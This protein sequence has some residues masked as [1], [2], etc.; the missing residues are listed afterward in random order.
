MGALTVVIV[1][2]V[3]AVAASGSPGAVEGSQGTDITLPTTNSSYTVKVSD[4]L[5]TASP[6]A[7]MTITVS[8][9][10]N[11]SNQ[12]V[13]VHWTGATPTNADLN[14]TGLFDDNYLQMFECWGPPDPSTPQNPGPGPD[15]CEFG[16]NELNGAM[17]SR[18]D[19][20]SSPIIRQVAANDPSTYAFRDPAGSGTYIP[21]QPVDG[22]SPINIPTT[23]ST[24][25]QE[26]GTIWQNP[27]FDYTTSNEIDYAR[28]YPDGTGTTLFTVDTGL[29]APGVGCGQQISQPDGSSVQPQCW[30]V[31]VPRGSAT[32]ENPAGTASST[33]PAVQTSPLSGQAFAHR[34]AIPLSFNAVGNSCQL[35]SNEERLVGSEL[36][37]PAVINWEPALCSTPKSPPY[38][39]SPI[40]DDQAR[41]ELITSA[42]T[43][44]PGMA[45]VSQPIDPAQVPPNQSITYAPLTESG[46]VVGFNIDRQLNVNANDPAESA[47]AGQKVAHIYLTPRLV[48][49]LLTESYSRAF[50]GLNPQNP[51]SQ[52]VWLKNNPQGLVDDPEFLQYNPEFKLLSCIAGPDC[53]NPIVEQ[54]SSDA[55]EAVWRWILADPEAA[56]WLSGKPDPW[57][58]VVNP[59]YATVATKNSTGSAFAPSGP[60]SS[61]PKADPYLYQDQT[62]LV[63]AN[64]QLPRPLSMGDITPYA[65]GLQAAA[66]EVRAANDGAKLSANYGAL[67]PEQVWKANGPQALGEEF[68]LSIT[69]SA[70]AAQYGL[71][72]ASLSRAGDDTADRAFVAADSAAIQ[73]GVAAMKPTPVKGVLQTNPA[74]PSR[75]AYPLPMVAYGAVDAPVLST[76][77]CR[78]YAS[79][80]DYA[81]GR[82]QTTGTAPGDLPLGYAPLS[83][84]LTA[85]AVAAGKTIISECGKATAVSALQPTSSH[86]TGGSAGGSTSVSALGSAGNSTSPVG[87]QS[88]GT[89]TAPNLGAG[90]GSQLGGRP[91]ASTPASSGAQAASGG[92]TVSGRTAAVSIAGSR[93]V[94]PVLIGLGAVSA[95]GWRWMDVLSRRARR[96]GDA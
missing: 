63:N 85:Q 17:I 33:T 32:Y 34:I 26:P 65:G 27:Y 68:L 39:F 66:L 29:E 58:M 86:P 46:V 88:A 12:A 67:T 22:T 6:F 47:L 96:P 36:A 53:A 60:P 90:P 42:A 48:A 10:H 2:A 83:A 51:P 50:F 15:G 44:G 25:P 38:Q 24:N 31:I 20:Q 77:F 75:A 95:L 56:A 41:Q 1:L 16:A 21:F 78:D 70:D 18:S 61:F 54:P 13:S 5:G 62:P 30:L 92:S 28:T 89:G 87:G 40:S 35:G 93:L 64:N 69:D 7:G 94:I 23:E 4:R 79:F 72:T 84:P 3:A 71:Q 57:G 8:Q 82:G 80:I 43:G 9:T 59:V 81:V 55:T 52:Y 45:V 74:P 73:A 91:R 14:P 49:K 11:L 19:G 76:T 37:Q